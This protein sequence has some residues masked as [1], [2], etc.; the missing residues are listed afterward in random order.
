MAATTSEDFV[1]RFFCFAFACLLY[2]T[3]RAVDILVQVKLTDEYEQ[4]PIVTADNTLTLLKKTTGSGRKPL[5]L[6]ERRL[7][8][9]NTASGLRKSPK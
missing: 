2:S 5:S 6:V 8:S 1:L 4:S 7:S 9:S 3:W